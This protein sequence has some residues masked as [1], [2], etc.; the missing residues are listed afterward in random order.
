MPRTY[1]TI[2][3]AALLAA[4]SVEQ[5]PYTRDLQPPPRDQ[6]ILF[7]DASTTVLDAA[8][9][10]DS[11]VVDD[12]SAVDAV[13]PDSGPLCGNKKIDPGE[14]C[15]PGI[16]GVSKGGCPTGC[17]SLDPCIKRQLRN[18][19]TCQAQ[20]VDQLVT[21]CQ[22]KDGCCPTSCNAGNDS[23]CNNSTCNN[24]TKEPNET[25]DTAIPAGN[26]GSCPTSCGDNNSCTSDTLVSP[27]TCQAQCL[28]PALVNGTACDSAT[29]KC[30]DGSC[31]KGCRQGASC[32]VGTSLSACGKDGDACSSCDTSDPCKTAVC[33]GGKCNYTNKL[34]GTLCSA[35]GKNGKCYA[36]SCCTGCIKNGVCD[37]Q[38]DTI[39]A[40]GTG[41]D[42]CQT[43]STT[44]NCRIAVCR[45]AQCDTD[46]GPLRQ[47]CTFGGTAGKCFNGNC[48]TGCWDGASCV[49]IPSGATK[50]CEG[51]GKD[52]S[53]CNAG[54]CCDIDGA[55]NLCRA[56]KPGEKVIGGYLCSNIAL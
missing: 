47:A 2:A 13:L 36:G 18:G 39:S 1:S 43:C 11:A 19:G 4:C 38:G 45:S 31:C 14:I 23:D 51:N 40:C 49:S 24:G 21:V 3:I 17:L 50:Y 32:E 35:S 48:C 5:T 30:L 15:D 29:G 7:N 10:Q 34:N 44:A 16:I 41:G 6:Q 25:C 22:N 52:C 28:F 37:P 8:P 12:A 26:A 9:Q 56:P 53:S 42:T 27:N 46:P 54:Q 20:C 33:S 55:Y